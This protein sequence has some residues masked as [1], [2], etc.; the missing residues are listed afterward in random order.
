MTAFV[1]GILGEWV[2]R[3]SISPGVG[4]LTALPVSLDSIHMT[5]EH[6]KYA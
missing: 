2:D 5:T 4:V 3:V 1:L 6:F